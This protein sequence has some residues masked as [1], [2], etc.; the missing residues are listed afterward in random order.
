MCLRHYKQHLLKTKVDWVGFG[1]E[2][3]SESRDVN[4]P[5]DGDNDL[6]LRTTQKSSYHN[7]KKGMDSYRQNERMRCFFNECYENTFGNWTKECI[8][9]RDLLGLTTQGKRFNLSFRI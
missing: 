1:T 9:V 3:T 2:V 5:G 8:I 6:P 4:N 7:V